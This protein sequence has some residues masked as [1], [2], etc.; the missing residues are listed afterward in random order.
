MAKSL[1]QICYEAYVR[2]TNGKSLVSGQHLP[3]WHGQRNDIKEA[4]EAAAEAVKGQVMEVLK[5]HSL[6]DEIWPK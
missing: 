5:L 4:W 6:S 1:G 3:I 2:H